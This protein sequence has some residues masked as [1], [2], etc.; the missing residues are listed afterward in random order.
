MIK[1]LSKYF[2]EYFIFTKSE[3]RGTIA[4]L[5]V[6]GIIILLRW[7]LPLYTGEYFNK[8]NDVEFIKA[9]SIIAQSEK[10][11]AVVQ[12]DTVQKLD[13]IKVEKPVAITHKKESSHQSNVD[14]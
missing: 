8:V 7:M 6:I 14:E 5:I 9:D 3:I 13:S 10:L 4:L 12:K 1:R 2:R 11:A